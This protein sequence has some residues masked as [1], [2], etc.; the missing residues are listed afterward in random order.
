MIIQKKQKTKIPTSKRD[1]ARQTERIYSPRVHGIADLTN[2]IPS[3]SPIT[4]EHTRSSPKPHPT[5]Q[6]PPPQ[7]NRQKKKN[8]AARLPVRSSTPRNATARGRGREKIP[9]TLTFGGGGGGGE[10]GRVRVVSWMRM[11]FV[12]RRGGVGKTGAFIAGRLGTGANGVAPR[13]RRARLDSGW[14]VGDGSRLGPRVSG[15]YSWRVWLASVCAVGG[16]Y[17]LPP[18]SSWDTRFFVWHVGPGVGGADV[19]VWWPDNVLKKNVFFL[20]LF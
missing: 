13:V 2:P 5:V 17:T 15:G 8:I 19:S 7:K 18:P 6:N 9:A 16:G 3:K 14:H 20:V 10:A 11:L 12:R 4:T 1:E